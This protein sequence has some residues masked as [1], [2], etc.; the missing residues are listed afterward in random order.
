MHRLAHDP[1]VAG[2]PPGP[3]GRRAEQAALADLLERTRLGPASLGIVG[4]AG[5]GK[6]ELVGYTVASARSLGLQVV[7]L[8]PTAAE[9]R[10]ANAGLRDLVAQLDP[11]AIEQLP[12]PQQHAIDAA[13]AAATP[14]TGTDRLALLAAVHELLDRSADVASV[15]VV[16]DDLQ[17]L[18]GSTAAALQYAA[19]R[20]AGPVG[21]L[22]SRRSEDDAAEGPDH[23]GEP[24]AIIVLDGLDTTSLAQVVRTR[25]PGLDP[26][27]VDDLVELAHGNPFVA[28]QLTIQLVAETGGRAGPIPTT[29][30]RSI[31]ALLESRLEQVPAAAR[32]V[33]A[34]ASA[35]ASPTVDLLRRTTTSSATL[36]ASLEAAEAAGIVGLGDG[37][38]RF[39]HPLLRHAC[40]A[41]MTPAARREV[42]GRLASS[43][44]APDERARHL[45]L[46]AIEPDADV[47]RA[48]DDAAASAAARGAT[49]DAAELLE[50]GLALGPHD[51]NGDRERTVEAAGHRLAAGDLRRAAQLLDAV[52]DPWCRT[53]PS[54]GL[55]A[56][57]RRSGCWRATSRRRRPGSTERSRPRST[58]PPEHG[59]RFRSPSC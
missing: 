44:S 8:A 20:V 56:S 25:E 27:V 6:T 31:D 12:R 30:P 21:F 49:V 13:V 45:A 34:V 18:D 35:V 29:L 58:R 5:I 37:T 19:R 40:Y 53:P 48:L 23:L 4:P 43:T 1:P 7:E 41:G 36:M 54:P 32:H 11:T 3:I 38:V 22:W 59:P 14:S 2:D 15:L 39:V 17:W 24:G 47:L 9:A 42:H 10:V 46:A 51:P 55:W 16:V 33:L 57:G 50:L 26:S 52:L 28:I